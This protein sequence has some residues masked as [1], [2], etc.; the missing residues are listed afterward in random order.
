MREGWVVVGYKV[1]TFVSFSG[2]DCF[3]F[4]NIQISKLYEFIS[5]F[6]NQG[7]CY[8][9]TYTYTSAVGGEKVFKL[10]EVLFLN[11]NVSSVSRQV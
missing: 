2:R 5:D 9:F 4:T 11:T 1:Y 3:V 10:F 6:V 7:L 8:Y